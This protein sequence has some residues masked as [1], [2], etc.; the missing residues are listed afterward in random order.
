MPHRHTMIFTLVA[1][2]ALVLAVAVPATAQQSPDFG[3]TWQLDT[4]VTLS[5]VAPTASILE[6]QGTCVFSGTAELTQEAEQWSGPATMDYVSG[7][8]ECP[9]EMFGDLVGFL[10]PGEAVGTFFIEGSISGQLG[11]LSFNGT[12]STNPGGEGSL[13]VDEGGFAGASGS[14]AAV[15]LEDVP[16]VLEIPTLSAVGLTLLTLT[17][18]AAGALVLRNAA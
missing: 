8:E 6:K 17:L 10:S 2:G 7:P 14:W 11:E 9:A 15:L 5:E 18:L 12:L 16:S 1:C 3:G 4:S 13:Q